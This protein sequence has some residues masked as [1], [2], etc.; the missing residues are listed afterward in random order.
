M[1]VTGVGAT[2][3]ITRYQVWHRRA[4]SRLSWTITVPCMIA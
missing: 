3:E 1:Q 4:R 2:S